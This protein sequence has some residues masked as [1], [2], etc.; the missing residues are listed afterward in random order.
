MIENMVVRQ[1][2]LLLFGK[3]KLVTDSTSSAVL[4]AALEFVELVVKTETRSGKVGCRLMFCIHS[5]GSCPK[6]SDSNHFACIVP[7]ISRGGRAVRNA[8]FKWT[9]QMISSKHFGRWP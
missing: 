6:P 4:V 9:K 3:Q 5:P 2:T 8:S 1:L 7:D